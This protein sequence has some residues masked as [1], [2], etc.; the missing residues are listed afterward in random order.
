[1]SQ[2]FT[3]VFIFKNIAVTNLTKKHKM[4]ASM[5]NEC[6]CLFIV[7]GFFIVL[8]SSCT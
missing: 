2:D 8:I 6:A 7:L 5:P 4:Y 1:M 3:F